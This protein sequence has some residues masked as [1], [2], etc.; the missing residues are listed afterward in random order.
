MAYFFVLIHMTKLL[1]IC[2]MTIII[3]YFGMWV[4]LS[5]GNLSQQK[6]LTPTIEKL[7]TKS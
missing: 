2:L 7:F 4:A 5:Q 1:F 3:K 6:Y